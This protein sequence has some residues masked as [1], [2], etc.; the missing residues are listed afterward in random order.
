M[1]CLWSKTSGEEKKPGAV[2]RSARQCMDGNSFISQP[3]TTVNRLYSP[4][5]VPYFYPQVFALFL[6]PNSFVEVPFK[7]T[8]GAPLPS[9]VPSGVPLS[10]LI[11]GGQGPSFQSPSKHPSLPTLLKRHIMCPKFSSG[12]PSFQSTFWGTP[13]LLYNWWTMSI[14]PITFQTPFTPNPSQVPYH[15]PKIFFRTTLLLKCILGCL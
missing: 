3:P 7:S 10:N 12:L 5:L 6:S 2:S 9:K 15:V 4:S 14:F 1:I 13:W 8:F 11:T